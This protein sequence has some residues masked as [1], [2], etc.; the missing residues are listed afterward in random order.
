MKFPIVLLRECFETVGSYSDQNPEVHG[1][2]MHLHEKICPNPTIA[3]R[4]KI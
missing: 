2:W 3:I 4:L 1:T